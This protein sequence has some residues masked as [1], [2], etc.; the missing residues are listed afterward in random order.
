[1]SQQVL[2]DGY[3][4]GTKTPQTT[5]RAEC[6]GKSMIGAVC[7]WQ[8]GS[9]TLSEILMADWKNGNPTDPNEDG[10][11]NAGVNAVSTGLYA[12][13]A[14]T[15]CRIKS[16]TAYCDKAFSS[17]GWLDRHMVNDKGL[18]W[19]NL[20]GK[21]CKL[22]DWVFTCEF[23]ILLMALLVILSEKSRDSMKM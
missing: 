2:K 8:V 4:K 13:T 17:L 21:D 22:T 23:P 15:L 19:D 12:L 3:L 7:E 14:A 5:I 10:N 9:A 6:N 20:N 16:D 11:T 18:L 1:M